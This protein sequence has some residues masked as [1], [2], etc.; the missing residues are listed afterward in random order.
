[1]LEN[2]YWM[3]AVF[4]WLAQTNMAIVIKVIIPLQSTWQA[5]KDKVFQ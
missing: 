2:F 3:L 5:Q 4:F 1:M